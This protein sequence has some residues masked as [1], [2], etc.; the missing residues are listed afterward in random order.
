MSE[1]A[2]SLADWLSHA[3]SVHSVGIDMGLERIAAVAGRLGFE[4][5]GHRCAPQSVIVAGTNGKGST[6][7]ALEALLRGAGLRVGTTLSPHVQRF[8]ERVRIDGADADD[9][10]LCRAFSA[11]EAVRGDVPLTYFEFSAL[12]A[13][14]TFR[15]RAVDVAVLEVGL[16]G[17][18]DAF[19]LVAAD[20]AVIT[21]IGLD[22]QAFLGDDLEGIGREK[23][24][25]LRPGQ[26]VVL[27]S[28]VTESVVAAAA[29]LGCRV[30]RLGEDFHVV[31]R[32]HDW[33]FVGGQRHAAIP[34]CGLAPDNCAL[35][36]EAAAHL[37]EPGAAAPAVLG[38]LLLPGRLERWQVGGPAGLIPLVLDVAHNPAA[39]RFLG[40]QLAERD[41]ERRFVALVAMLEDKNAAGVAA[42]LASRVRY[43]VCV[44]TSGPRGLSGTAL[45]GRLGV[46]AA[47]VAVADPAEGLRRALSLAESGDGILALGSFNLVESFRGALADGL[48]GARPSGWQGMAPADEPAADA[49]MDLP[50]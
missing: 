20:V 7:V 37:S 5:P 39:A 13:L 2:R 15:E 42:S 31:A 36:L 48:A 14:W 9:A 3:E 16:G 47:A 34:R 8:N 24:G 29:G 10:L 27:G 19:N 22:H 28:D 21:S 50:I 18:L 35:A 12:V 46:G 40:R 49:T 11:V 1:S 4:A 26:R 6:C 32:R 41:P 44:P 43:W 38:E 33:D 17:R 25:V 45:A 30:S 23:A